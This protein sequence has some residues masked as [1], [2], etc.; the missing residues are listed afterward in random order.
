LIVKELYLQLDAADYMKAVYNGHDL[1]KCRTVSRSTLGNII[2]WMKK[3]EDPSDAELAVLSFLLEDAK[4]DLPLSFKEFIK[5]DRVYR[6]A[7]PY[8]AVGVFKLFE[9]FDDKKDYILSTTELQSFKELIFETMGNKQFKC[10][11]VGKNKPT[12]LR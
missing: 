2:R 11:F 1:N 4:G 12:R 3:G 6:S 9:L 8:L 7:F 10:D 5:L